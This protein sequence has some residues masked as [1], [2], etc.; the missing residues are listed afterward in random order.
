MPSFAR[1]IGFAAL[2][3]FTGVGMGAFGAHA[4]RDTLGPAAMSIYKTG[5]DYQMWHALALG[6]VAI[7]MRA[8][9]ASGLLIWTAR[10]MSSGIL[11][12][13]GSLYLLSVTGFRWLGA[14]TPL[15]GTLFLVAWLLLANYSYQII[16]KDRNA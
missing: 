13:S 3:G 14:I 4:L 7:L 6:M 11:L 8:D 5:V 15:G 16:G 10:L 12:F 9:T 1:Y 2:L